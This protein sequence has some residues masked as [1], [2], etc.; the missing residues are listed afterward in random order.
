MFQIF[1]L[2]MSSSSS[3][4]D[5]NDKPGS[6]ASTLLKLIIRGCMPLVNKLGRYTERDYPSL[7]S[8]INTG[9]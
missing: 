3:E 8:V 1:N 2:R 5:D 9:L 7:N 6:R 4:D